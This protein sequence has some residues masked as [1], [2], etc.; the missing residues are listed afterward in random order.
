MGP[1]RMSVGTHETACERKFPRTLIANRS[2]LWRRLQALWVVGDRRRLLNLSLFPDERFTRRPSPPTIELLATTRLSP[3]P[4]MQGNVFSG[5]LGCLMKE[6]ETADHG[7]QE[8]FL[9]GQRVVW[10]A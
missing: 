6:K 3:L 5:G 10:K 1:K 4:A 2:H 8:H 7:P 9:H